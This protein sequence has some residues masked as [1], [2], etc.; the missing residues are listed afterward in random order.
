ML[1]ESFFSPWKYFLIYSKSSEQPSINLFFLHIA[2][3]LQLKLLPAELINK[4]M[5]KCF[6]ISHTSLG[7]LNDM[8][9]F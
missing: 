5:K 6:R 8:K 3:R 2:S 4:R 1:P 9:I 7:H